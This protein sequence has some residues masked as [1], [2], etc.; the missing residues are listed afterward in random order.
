MY[1]YWTYVR[2]IIRNIHRIYKDFSLSSQDPITK[3][4]SGHR[5]DNIENNPLEN[6]F[7]GRVG[8]AQWRHHSKIGRGRFVAEITTP[9]LSLDSSVSCERTDLARFRDIDIEF[10]GG[11]FATG[12]ITFTEP[13]AKKIRLGAGLSCDIWLGKQLCNKLTSLLIGKTRRLL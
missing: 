13:F 8:T 2:T 10:R 1:K 4:I 9:L 6:D 5:R 3:P 12:A 11:G 7:L